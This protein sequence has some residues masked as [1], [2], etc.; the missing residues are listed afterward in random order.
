VYAQHDWMTE[1]AC[2]NQPTDIFFPEYQGNT[3]PRIWDQAREYCNNCTV[4][5]QCLKLAMSFE[6]PDLRRHGMWGG[7]TPDERDKLL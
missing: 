2:L 4:K 1:S 6:E 5:Y 3:S 7:L